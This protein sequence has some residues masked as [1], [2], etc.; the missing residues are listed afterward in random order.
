MPIGRWVLQE[1]TRQ[2]AEWQS[3]SPLG[4]LRISVNVSARQFQHPDLVG[5]VADAL[6]AAGLD[7]QLLTLEITE[8]LFAQD[9]DETIRRSSSSRSSASG[10]R[11]TT[12]APAT[13][14]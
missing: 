5:D 14:R 7:P 8:S 13:R 6:R 9:T 4:R 12:S 10:W 11:S 2:A 3:R 1:A